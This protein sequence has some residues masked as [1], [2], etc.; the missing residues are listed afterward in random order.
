LTSEEV[1]EELSEWALLAEC[2]EADGRR[3]DL[4]EESIV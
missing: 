1:E 3:R 4:R 2:P